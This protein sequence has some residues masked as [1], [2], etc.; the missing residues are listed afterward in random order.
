MNLLTPPAWK[1]ETA[2]AKRTGATVAKSATP[3]TAWTGALASAGFALGVDQCVACADED[4]GQ[5][6][7]TRPFH[8]V[9]HLHTVFD[10]AEPAT[11]VSNL[12]NAD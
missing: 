5:Q 8:A 1:V 2:A 11:V 9:L 10:V 12:L 3:T 4:S 6:N 7:D